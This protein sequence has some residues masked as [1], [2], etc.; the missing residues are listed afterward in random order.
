MDLL[1]CY[2]SVESILSKL[3]FDA[4]FPGFHRYRYALYNSAEICLDGVLFSFDS[5]FRGNTSIKYENDYIAI[6]NLE[7]DPVDDMELLAYNL[8]HEMFHCH[9]NTLHETRFP[10]D[11]LLL[12]YPFDTENYTAKLNENR[13]LAEAFEFH[14]LNAFKNFIAIR[15]RRLQQYPT[16][17]Q[18]ELNAETIEGMAE[19]IGGKALQQIAPAKFRT[20]IELLLHTVRSESTLQYDIRRISY[21]TGALL[22]HCL[23]VLKLGIRNDFSST[24]SLYEQNRLSSTSQPELHRFPLFEQLHHTLIQ[25]RQYILDAHI[26]QHDFAA[27]ECSI[28][29]YDPMNMFRQDDL[30]YCRHFVTLMRNQQIQ[31]ISRPVVLVM[32]KGSCSN[33]IGYY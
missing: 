3:N 26:A 30:I 27:C 9:Q 21:Y 22:L 7:L 19:Y 14:N 12:Q 33:V 6:W 5:R 16:P 11:L 20:S 2:R 25:E 32:Q 17:V 18:Q 4:L 23:E 1:S 15:D 31:T 10:S 29:G 28:C 8:V 24:L 13:Y